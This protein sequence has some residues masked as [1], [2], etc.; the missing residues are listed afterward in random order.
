MVAV[1]GELAAGASM[2]GE[3]ICVGR[4]NDGS[5]RGSRREEVERAWALMYHQFSPNL[6]K[7]FITLCA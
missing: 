2:A 4:S 5:R 1:D 7:S 3:S 6:M